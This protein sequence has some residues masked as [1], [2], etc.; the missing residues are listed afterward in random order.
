[1]ILGKDVSNLDDKL[2]QGQQF[3]EVGKVDE[4]PVGRW[5]VNEKA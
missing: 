3:L 1:M 4:V 2:Q 5:M